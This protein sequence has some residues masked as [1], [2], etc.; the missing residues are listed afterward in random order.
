[1]S[2]IKLGFAPTQ[3]PV[4]D[5]AE[6]IKFK[7]LIQEK[8]AQYNIDLC[9]IDAL[10]PD[11]L[12][13]RAEDAEMVS[14]Y[15]V[16][17]EVDA[18]FFPHCDFGTEA[19]VARVAKAVGK[20]V[21][22][23]GPRDDAPQTNG[24]RLRDTQ[25]GLFA[26]TKVLNLFGVPFT[27]ITNSALESAT[28]DEGFRNFISAAAVVK[29]FTGM[30]IGQISTRPGPFYSVIY[31]EGELLEKFG[32]EVIPTTLTEMEVAVRDL[33]EANPD[34]LKETVEGFQQK[35]GAANL[36]P[37]QLKHMAAL[38]LAILDWAKREKLSGASIQCWSALQSAL[39]IVPCF[40]NGELT[41]E[42][43]PVACESD[44]YGAV[45]SVMAQALTTEPVFFADLTIRH[46]D[47]ENAELLWH[48]GN[49]PYAL[50]EK[51]EKTKLASL[52]TWAAIGNWE[53]H[54]GEI[55]LC[56]FGGMNGQFSMLMG[57]GKAVEGPYTSGTY[58]WADMG[59]WPLWENRF[60]RGPYIHH[61]TGIYGKY[62]PALYEACRYIPGLAAD[63]VLPTVDEIE[64]IWR[65]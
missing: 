61:C 63:P 48:C 2:R 53:L 29:A 42:G 56:R 10:E 21:L 8:L 60:I 23:W 19:A 52:G 46:P 15:F 4:F 57:H 58:L 59:D 30:R 45:T 44:V 18:V 55:T 35:P 49:F 41:A 39:N 26:T 28:F 7:G 12:L 64:K 40:I 51:T 43:F 11:G 14:K 33:V 25:C 38:K 31:N 65:G 5:K 9:T 34:I 50:A 36:D 32:I 24:S 22:I 62:A 1:M 27:Y 17:Q 20:P 37:V 47:N 54:K 16:A 13:R 3:R 6:A